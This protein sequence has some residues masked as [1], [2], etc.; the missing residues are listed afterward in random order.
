MSLKNSTV[1]LGRG[2][3]IKSTPEIRAKRTPYMVTNLDIPVKQVQTLSH[4]LPKV[5]IHYA[6]KSNDDPNL[7]TAIDDHVAGYDIASLGEL[8]KLV[9]LNISPDRILYSNPVKI[10]HH[11]EQAYKLGVRYFAVDSLS[12]IE[13]IALHAPGSK[14]YVRFRVS[15]YGSKFPLSKKFGVDEQHVV[16]YASMAH[17]LGLDVIGVAFHVGSQSENVQV[18][19]SAILSAGNLIKAMRNKGINA[20]FIDIGGGFPAKYGQ[21]IPT[22]RVI[23]TAIKKA[24]A[25]HVPEDVEIAAEPGRYISAE[26]SM[27]VATIIGRENRSGTEWLYL[28]IGTF[29][30]L[31]EPLEMADWHYP[32]R[33]DMSTRSYK[34]NY[35]LSG[36]SCD[37]YDTLG[38]GYLLPSALNVGDRVY[39]G[40]VGAYSTVYGS[41][42][43]G[44]EIP[45][46]YYVTDEVK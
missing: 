17:D 9:K 24:I 26:S 10:P 30:G 22:M 18:W 2:E 34:I 43:N 37:A 6:I 23:T 38:T 44:F 46:T 41:N 35:V 32:I 16:D 5:S 45:S 8:K 33:T 20:R 1:E 3:F 27:M 11:V 21:P 40:S 29:Q 42:F 36:P 7:I 25:H 39:I 31:I 4:L 28:D 12:E 14:V 13:K 15:D 19:E